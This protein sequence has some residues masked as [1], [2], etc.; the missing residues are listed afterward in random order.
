[1]NDKPAVMIHEVDDVRIWVA[2][3]AVHL[4]TA[5]PYDDPVEL[6]GDDARRLGQL[7]ATLADVADLT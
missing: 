7:L 6:T 2:D 1:M 4:R 5:T 3:G